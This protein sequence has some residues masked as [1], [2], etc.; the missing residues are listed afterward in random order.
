MAKAT[1]SKGFYT[2]EQIRKEIDH[3]LSDIPPKIR[4]EVFDRL[5]QIDELQKDELA[6]IIKLVARQYE[7]SLVEPGEAIGTVA[8]QSIGEPGT[9]MSIPGSELVV[10][11]HGEMSA[12]VPIGDFVDDLIAN[13]GSSAPSEV[14]L[15]SAITNIPD[16]L[17]LY[18]PAL[19]A[20]EQVHW[21]KLLQVSRHLPSGELLKISTRTGREITAT[22]SHSFVIRKD[23]EIIPIK[24]GELKIG[25]RIPL[26]RSF[27]SANPLRKLPLDLYLPR[28]EVWYGSELAKAASVREETGRDWL[29]NME[30]FSVPVEVDGLRVALDTGKTEIL[31]PGFV[32][33]KMHHS[34]H[35]MIPEELELDSLTG[36]FI[37][38]YLAEGTNAGTFITITNADEGYRK[39]AA[40]FTDR[41]DVNHSTTE[42]EGAYG[43]SISINIHSTLLAKLFGRMCGKGANEKHIPPWTINCN[44][45]FISN[46]LKA[47]FDGDGSF[48]P[49][50]S[51]IRASSNSK[52]LRDEICLLL[53]RFE[54]HTT[55][56]SSEN[57]KGQRQYWLRIPGKYAPQFKDLI[58]S[59]IPHKRAALEQLAKAEEDK[60]QQGKVTYDAVDMIPG[61]GTLLK[62]VRA[63]LEISS[64]SSFGV[65]IRKF[66][67]KQLIGRQTLGR[68]I[69]EFKETASKKNIDIR[70]EMRILHRAYHS[71][72]VW[73]EITK[74]ELVPSPTEYIYDFSV[75]G[76]E[77]FVTA[78]GLVTHNT[79][80]TFHYAGVAELNV[81]LGLP[82]LIEILDAR[83]NPASPVM[84]V[85]LEEEYAKDREEARTVQRR[86][87][88]TTVEKVA[89]SIDTDLAAMKI[90]ITLNPKLMADKGISKDMI[91]ENL[92][93]LKKGEITEE[94]EYMI[95]IQSEEISMDEIYKYSEK[96]RKQKLKGIKGIERVIMTKE[97][98]IDEWVLYTEGSNIAE[99]FTIPG[100][101]PSRTT[102]NNIS[103]ICGT[104]GIEA[105]RNAI[106][107]EAVGVLSE[108]GLD[109][110]L[111]HLLLVADLMTMSG[112]LRQIG[113]HGISGQKESVLSR[114]SFEVTV[115]HLL[116]S[117]V[118][119]EVDRL[120][121]I[122]ENVIIGQVIPVGTGIV[123]L[124]MKL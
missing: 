42:S 11:K 31:L 16:D 104:L 112:A 37:G 25:H 15:H 80:K 53:S 121:G 36:W 101:D 14:L 119:G 71:G 12:I 17:E 91:M 65:T 22:L 124:I 28:D 56:H 93:K 30:S 63:K 52:E 109:V 26:V 18:V 1:R 123:D 102:T 111:R 95:S 27:P 77:T 78:E 103:E 97:R 96:I 64:K 35:T 107:N 46:I 120:R 66:T 81:T 106:V 19:G 76:L 2:P 54:I 110:D 67:R 79:L 8:A 88:L 58:G 51:Q 61:F 50:R 41:L 86:I 24:G 57:E 47:Y 33:P 94:G 115:K 59:D 92:G 13:L 118:R 10:V 122:T 20:D 38:A 3:K 49:Q 40:E 100:V 108:Q 72:V 84:K 114:A 6:A 55:K 34:A 98:A 83:K 7:R 70:E 43:P 29:Q 69:T 90:A 117:S 62:D 32:Y 60:K 82:R 116:E 99:V 23:N 39:L 89:D 68:Y 113:R 85:Y 45:N 87:E 48:S 74:L 5:M 9:Q 21:R 105:A 73:D 44:E 75:D 4:T